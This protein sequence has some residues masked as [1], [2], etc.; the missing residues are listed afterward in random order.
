LSYGYKN[1]I[2]TFFTKYGPAPCDKIVTQNTRPSFPFT[3][4]PPFGEGL[5][6]RL[7]VDVVRVWPARLIELVES[8]CR[9]STDAQYMLIQGFMTNNTPSAT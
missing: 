8:I 7:P 3:L 1:A 2:M 9:D 5:G 6:T 4:F